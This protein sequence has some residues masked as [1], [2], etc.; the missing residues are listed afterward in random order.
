VIVLIDASRL[1]GKKVIGAQAF[2][3][4]EVESVKLDVSTWQVTHLGVGL[5]EEATKELGFKKPFMSHVIISL[6]IATVSVVGDVIT[7]D[8][9][10]KSLK[11]VVARLDKK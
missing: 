7:L 4:S 11:D 8:K 1:I 6:P 2:V 9:S 3:L 10:I 5:T